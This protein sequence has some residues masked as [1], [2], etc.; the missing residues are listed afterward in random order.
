MVKN[1]KRYKKELEK[2]EHFLAK[3][4]IWGNAHMDFFPMTFTFPSNPL[5]TQI[6]TPSFWMSSKRTP[7]P[8]G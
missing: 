6:S 2:N 3:D 7:M 4:E 1:L 8:P 5:T